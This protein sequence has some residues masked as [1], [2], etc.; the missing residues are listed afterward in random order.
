MGNTKVDQLYCAVRFKR[1][2]QQVLWF[3]VMVSNAM[4]ASARRFKRKGSLMSD[5][6]GKIYVHRPLIYEFARRVGNVFYDYVVGTVMFADLCNP[7][8]IR[9]IYG[10]D[11]LCFASKAFNDFG[12]RQMRMQYLQCH[13]ALKVRIKCVIDRPLTAGRQ[14]S[15][16]LI[17]SDC[18]L[19]FVCHNCSSV[20]A[21]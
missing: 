10:G 5:G 4:S 21:T 18:L 19:R 3:D 7:R 16:D 8:Y 12:R 14:A 17:L 13:I 20:A 2:Q 15:D 6:R 9:M 1:G 11:Y